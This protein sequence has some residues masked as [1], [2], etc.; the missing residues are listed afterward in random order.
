MPSDTRTPDEIERDIE[1]ERAELASTVDALQDKFSPDAVIREITRGIRD[2]GGEFGTAVTRSI[3][4]NPL[5][6]AL[7][8]VGLAWLVFG[9]SHETANHADYRNGRD[10]TGTRDARLRQDDAVHGTVSSRPSRSGDDVAGGY[11]AVNGRNRPYSGPRSLSN[12]D[13]AHRY[14]N[15]PDWARHDLDDRDLDDDGDSGALANR[16]S[17]AASAVGNAASST[18]SG[19]KG[20]ANSVASGAKAAGSSMASGVNKTTSTVGSRLQSAGST[21]TAGA[22]SAMTGARNA[23]RGTAERAEQARKRLARGTENLTEAARERVIAARARAVDVAQRA[24]AAAR[25]RYARGRDATRDFIEEQPLVAGALALAVGAALAG[26]LPRTRQEDELLGE[27]RDRLFDEAERI[28]EEERRKAERV[29]QAAVD[30][31]GKIAEEKRADADNA[32][33]GSKSAVE[34]AADEVRDA[35]ERVKEAARK[36]AEQENVGKPGE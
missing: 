4:Q 26:A 35:G 8:G 30:E 17:N 12:D 22:S 2:H 33:P 15:Y 31:A 13:R 20:V 11:G 18:A 36:K 10:L 7:T 25:Q 32:A 5:A 6:L 34:A 28:F 21:V 1:R 24:D 27:T 3:K 19:A 29:A 16:A 23:A 9:R 14:S